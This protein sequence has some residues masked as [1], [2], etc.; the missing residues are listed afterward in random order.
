[1]DDDLK[2]NCSLNKKDETVMYKMQLSALRWS[3]SIVTHSS[4]WNW[5][6][7]SKFHHPLIK[8]PLEKIVRGQQSA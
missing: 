6:K 4:V 8:T 5:P 2:T 1:M 7:S 3:S